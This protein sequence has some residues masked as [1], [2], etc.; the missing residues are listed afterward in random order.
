LFVSFDGRVQKSNIVSKGIGESKSHFDI[1][2]LFSSSLLAISAGAV[3]I[4]FFTPSLLEAD[5]TSNSPEL[6][7]PALK[8]LSTAQAPFV[9]FST[10]LYYTQKQRFA[11]TPYSASIFDFHLVNTLTRASKLMVKCSQASRLNHKN[12]IAF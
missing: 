6:F 5:F 11:R 8:D 4:N 2:S 12:F 7:I 10:V 1:C 9:A 3:S